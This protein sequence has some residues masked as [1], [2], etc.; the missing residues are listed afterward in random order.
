MKLFTWFTKERSNKMCE[1]YLYKA[2]FIFILC[3]NLVIRQAR[4]SAC[5]TIRHGLR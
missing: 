5:G 2:W 3:L 4:T 1:W